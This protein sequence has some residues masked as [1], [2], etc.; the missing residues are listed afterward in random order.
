MN[1]SP[2]TQY[3]FANWPSRYS[4]NIVESGVKDH[5]QNPNTTLKVHMCNELFTGDTI[6][7]RK[8]I[9]PLDSLQETQS[10]TFKI[11]WIFPI[12]H[13]Q[14]PNTTLKVHTTTR[15]DWRNRKQVTKQ[16]KYFSYIVT[17]SFIGGGNR[18][19]R[20]KPLTC[21]KNQVN[22]TMNRIRTHDSCER[23]QFHG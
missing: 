22:F 19:A 15:K 11:L 10:W 2:E 6:Y 23:H 14:N 17:V 13:N 7:F 21:C 3:I 5:N 18:S 1:Y 12:L 16:K 8:I 9:N 20:R 4:W